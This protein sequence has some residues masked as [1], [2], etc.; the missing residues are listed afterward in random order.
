MP[1]ASNIT[2]TE[3][4]I[5]HVFAPIT[6]SAAQ[7]ILTTSEANTPLGEMDLILGFQ[8]FN[9]KRSTD[10]V[11]VALN[12]PIELGNATDGYRV[13]DIARAKTQVILPKG[14]STADRQKFADLLAAA[15]A[16]A[17][18]QGYFER[19]PLY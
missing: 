3:N 6:A 14:I 9:S 4:A 11:D 12:M 7:T 17:I 1:A 16:E 5:A 19:K 13:E 2:L 8:P 10:R 15:F 18:V